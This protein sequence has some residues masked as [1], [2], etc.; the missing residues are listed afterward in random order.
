MLFFQMLLL[1]G[2][3]YAHGLSRRLAPRTQ[4]IV[5]GVLLVAALASLPI[6]PGDHWK[7]HD[8]SD[9]TL[10]ILLLLGASLGLPYLVLS[11]TGPLMQEWFRRLNP[12][13]SPYRLYALSNVGS[14]LALVSYPFFIETQF[15]RK[16]QAQMWSWGLV[17]YA[18][19]CG[20]CAWRLWR[21]P[22]AGPVAERIAE[23]AAPAPT[24]TL[25]LLWLGLPACGSV[26]LL[27][28][29]NKMCQDVAV[30][31]FL[32]VLP[33]ALYLVTFIVAFDS[34]RW[35]SRFY[36]LVALVAALVFGCVAIYEGADAP[37][38]RQVIIYSA[39]MFVACMVC[40]GEVC[41]LKPH[42]R[43]LTSFYL[44]IS[45]GGAVGGLFVALVAPAIF[46]NFYELHLGLAAMLL[47]ALI[48][49]WRDSAAM[50][51]GRWR[52]LA[53]LL[54]FAMAV[55]CDRLLDGGWVGS[56]NYRWIAWGVG[57]LAVLVGGGAI[58]RRWEFN[59]HRS[60]CAVL[61]A[62]L[63][64]LSVL[65]AS[66]V[67]EGGQDVVLTGRNF[68]GV[69]SVLEHRKLEPDARYY[70]L[71]HGRITHG[72][73]F[74]A[75]ERAGMI[76]SYFG[77]RTGIGL[78]FKSYPRQGGIRIGL[79]GLGVGTIAAYGQTGD[80]LRIYEINPHVKEI[81]E[82]PFSYLALSKAKVD[83][84]MG[85]G[86]LSM[87]NEPPQN[88]DFLIMDAFS[89]DAVPVHLLTREAF[90]IYLR[91]LKDGGV[92][93]VNISNRFLDLRPVVE[94]AA[95][96]FK[97]RSH[98]IASEDG[99]M[100]EA[101]EG[102]WWLYGATWMVLS[103]NLEFMNNRELTSAASP[104]ASANTIP[105]WTDDYTSMFRILQ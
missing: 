39:V 70:T 6:T 54:A 80:Y 105:L 11:A 43:H 58:W 30:I 57:G 19:G 29:T 47:L 100:G 86:R 9:P 65:L 28:V 72:L 89:S 94:N 41:R 64:G 4:A 95:R 59:G 62:G 103:K 2:Y 35:Y 24:L 14:L 81:A 45:A 88:F 92:I 25:R 49:S 40:H 101:E 76:T 73:Q 27:A 96:E 93:L 33:L 22:T 32:W 1:G 75:P 31:P 23:T 15:T 10:R 51:P 85:D 83:V 53:V 66:H 91:H 84:V 44:M 52:L 20:F 69:L 34:P 18:I 87:E 74:A 50:S 77:P 99:D 98:T 17:A 61:G 97:L 82:K 26:L 48:V 16:A 5:H 38:Q 42:P 36:W 7:P 67:K 79:L 68:Y 21:Q 3:A 37:I 13:A 63:I 56:P 102:A 78:A 104:P 71:L 90:A 60:T 8:A 55:A 12:G 46:N